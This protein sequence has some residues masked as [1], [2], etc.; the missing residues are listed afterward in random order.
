[1]NEIMDYSKLS[2]KLPN[3]ILEMLPEIVTRFDLTTPLRLCHFL[4]QTAHESGGFK[5]LTENLNYS[6]EGLLKTFP[7]YFTSETALLYARKPEKIA[8][9]VYAN[10]MGNGTESSGEGY[11]FRGRGY[12]QLTGKT[13][14]TKFGT[15]INENLNNTPDLVATPKYA[16]MS[17]AW[18]FYINNISKSSDKGATIDVIKEVTKK[19]NGGLTGLDDRVVQFNKMYGCYL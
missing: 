19:V 3:T 5:V 4:G 17:A 11:K 12:I 6:A 13:N 2:G 18:F 7:K 14:Y 15:T 8:N 16:L 1:M 9:K 10:R